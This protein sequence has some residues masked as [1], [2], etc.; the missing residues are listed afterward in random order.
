MKIMN[1]NN[2][3]YG[4]ETSSSGL[5]KQIEKLNSDAFILCNYH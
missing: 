5:F 3:N 4:K 1:F 2:I